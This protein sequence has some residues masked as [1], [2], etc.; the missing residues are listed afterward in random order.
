VR[1]WQ[2]ESRDFKIGKGKK[3]DKVQKK[4]EDE[5][6][7]GFAVNQLRTAHPLNH[8]ASS[9]PARLVAR[10]HVASVPDAATLEGQGFARLG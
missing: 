8:P 4:G 3:K 9:G 10:L 2:A 6:M 7:L 1:L 5:E